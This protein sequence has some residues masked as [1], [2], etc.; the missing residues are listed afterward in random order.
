M[1][2]ELYY[3]FQIEDKGLEMG[4]D[5]LGGNTNMRDLYKLPGTL[6]LQ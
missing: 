1:E 4:I 3:H 2:M 6:G 5:F